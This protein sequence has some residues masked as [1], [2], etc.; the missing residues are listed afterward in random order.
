MELVK[1]RGNKHAYLELNSQQEE[2]ILLV[3]GHPFDHTMWK[4]QHE[5]LSDFRLLLPDLK[6]YGQS[7]YQFDKIYIEEQ[8]LDLAL[9]LDTLNIEKVHLVGLS[10]G[11]QII[12]EFMRLFPQR[13]KS[14]VICASTPSAENEIS[15]QNRLALAS[16]IEEIGMTAYTEEDIYKYI[17]LARVS[18]DSQVYQHLYQMMTQTKAIGA[19]AAHR[20]RA[21]RRDNTGFLSEINVPTLVVAGEQDFFFKVKNVE[22]VATKIPAAKFVL[23]K[24]S[25]HLPNMEMP[26]EFNQMLCSF[27]KEEVV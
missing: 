4:Y 24:E 15:Y 22:K 16:K 26:E 14:L 13:V 23:V 19:A 11:G 17:N 5:A 12:V 1:I 20:G 8:A 7:D 6:G 25:G 2:V 27:Y 21:E 3:H 9:L 10:M 18:S